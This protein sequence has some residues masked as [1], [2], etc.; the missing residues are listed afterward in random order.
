MAPL[1]MK[2]VLILTAGF[3]EGHNTAARNIRAALQDVAGEEVDAQ[4]LDLLEQ[5]FGRVNELFRR[6]YIATI[7][8]APHLWEKIYAMLD[9]GTALQDNLQLL[10]PLGETMKR[11]LE[12]QQPYA[13]VSTYPLYNYF[14][15][16]LYAEKPRPFSQITV[17]TDSISINSIWYR[18]YSDALLVA[19]D[20]TA[21]VLQE[22]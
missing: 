6:A 8:H 7:N 5:T 9:N 22:A 16:Q 1:R 11:L 12:E 3:G 2:K 17:I 19:N 18:C 20:D 10:A 14:L 21:R 13:I 15:D 4:V